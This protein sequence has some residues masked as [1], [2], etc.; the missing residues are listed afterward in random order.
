MRSLGFGS[1][2]L[3]TSDADSAQH[4]FQLSNHFN[5]PYNLKMYPTGLASVRLGRPSL[6]L[7]L[8][9][10]DDAQQIVAHTLFVQ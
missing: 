6:L 7:L 8:V 1:K 10:G 2:M 5:M 9:A 3:L 4:G